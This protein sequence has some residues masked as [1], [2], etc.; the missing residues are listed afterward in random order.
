MTAN[1]KTVAAC[2]LLLA[3]GCANVNSPSAPT[4]PATTAVT[5]I[6]PVDSAELS[7]ASDEQKKY[8]N[9]AVQRA[10][11]LAGD[12]NEQFI[13]AG[14]HERG[15]G[16][17]QSYAEAAN[18]YRLA[19]DQGHAAAQFYL[20][21]MYGSARGVTRSYKAAIWWYSKSAAQ[22]YRDALYPMAFAYEYGI[23]VAGGINL[24]V[25]IEWYVKSADAGVW[26]A[27]ERL[28]KAYK[29]GELG[30]TVDVDKAKEWFATSVSTQKLA[31]KPP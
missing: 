4:I 3:T 29:N 31:V 11:A 30:L 1:L 25:A 18:W 23:G 14:M 15:E 2:L 13:L 26:Q 17:P 12:A 7:V 22:G 21:A 24:P 16:A 6:A 27:M 20:G 8:P 10:K 19:A 9:F 5:S 28:G